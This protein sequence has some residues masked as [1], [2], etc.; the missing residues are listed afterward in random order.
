MKTL[1]KILGIVAIGGALAGFSGY[2]T[3]KPIPFAIGVSG[4]AVGGIGYVF[5]RSKEIEDELKYK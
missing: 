3:N 4:L 2:M 5:A 1:T